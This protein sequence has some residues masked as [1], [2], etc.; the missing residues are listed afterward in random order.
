MKIGNI[1]NIIKINEN[2]SI[3]NE[4]KVDDKILNAIINKTSPEF[5][6]EINEK[7]NNENEINKLNNIELYDIKLYNKKVEDEPINYYDNFIII[8][9]NI[10]NLILELFKIKL[11]EK[12]K[13][14]F[15]DN[16]FIMNP[17]NNIQNSIITGYVDKDNIFKIE[18]LLKLYDNKCIEDYF[19]KFSL[20]GYLNTIYYFKFNKKDKIPLLNEKNKNNEGNVYKINF[21]ENLQINTEN[22]KNMNSNKNKIKENPS[23]KN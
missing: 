6:K 17:Q 2:S 14:L 19:R 7:I 21:T 18:I 8:N 1:D 5:L 4:K 22:P 10:Y 11:K 23:S 13:F 3:I 16:K 9:D 12:D 15:G 20:N